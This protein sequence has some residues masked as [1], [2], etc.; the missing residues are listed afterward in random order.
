MKKDKIRVISRV[1]DN[2]WKGEKDGKEGV[3][4]AAYVKI[5]DSSV[6]GL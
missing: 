1:D 2:W 5:L 4:P 3:F 6:N